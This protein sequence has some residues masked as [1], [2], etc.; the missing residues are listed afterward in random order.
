MKEKILL[1]NYF[2]KKCVQKEQELLGVDSFSTGLLGLVLSHTKMV[3]RFANGCTSEEICFVY[4]YYPVELLLA[5]C[6]DAKTNGDNLLAAFDFKQARGVRNGVYRE[7][8]VSEKDLDQYLELVIPSV[9]SVEEIDYEAY[10]KVSGLSR[11]ELIKK[12]FRLDNLCSISVEDLEV[13]KECEQTKMIDRAWERLSKD[14]RFINLFYVGSKHT[15]RSQ[16]LAL[17]YC[18]SDKFKT[19]FAQELGE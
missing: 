16:S 4:R 8:F 9:K 3:R 1:F 5:V 17:C 10:Y 15:P 11:D 6:L 13:A 18:T 19:I 7:F 12:S 14:E 2:L